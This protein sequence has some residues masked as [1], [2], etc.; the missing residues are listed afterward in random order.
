MAEESNLL[1]LEVHFAAFTTFEL[2][3]FYSVEGE[4]MQ[5]LTSQGGTMMS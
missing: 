3:L 2:F 5:P 1:C 4:G